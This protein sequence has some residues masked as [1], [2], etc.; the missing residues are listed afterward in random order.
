MILLP[1]PGNQSFRTGATVRLGHEAFQMECQ[2]GAVN[3]NTATIQ[4]QSK[5]ASKDPAAELLPRDQRC[6]LFAGNL[7]VFGIC[8]DGADCAPGRNITA[9]GTLII[10]H[11]VWVARWFTDGLPGAG[12]VWWWGGVVAGEGFEPSTFRL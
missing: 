9:G 1:A 2:K 12:L 8:V 3:G 11:S 4:K 6:R 10:N 7:A 5:W